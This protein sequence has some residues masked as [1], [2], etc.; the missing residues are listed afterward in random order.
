MVVLSPNFRLRIAL[1]LKEKNVVAREIARSSVG[2]DVNN[3][4]LAI[5]NIFLKT[6]ALGLSSNFS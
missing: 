3:A 5:N 6:S 1:S 2:S 4:F